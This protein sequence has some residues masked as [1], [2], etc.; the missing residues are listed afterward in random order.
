MDEY[1]ELELIFGNSLGGGPFLLK[2]HNHSKGTCAILYA[3]FFRFLNFVSTDSIILET[4][5]ET[6]T[7]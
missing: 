7:E 5:N 6:A 1:R 2:S 3:I 4:L